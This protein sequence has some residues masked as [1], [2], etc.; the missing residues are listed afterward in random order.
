MYSTSIGT[1]N[2]RSHRSDGYRLP[3]GVKVISDRLREVGVFTGNIVNLT[4][5]TDEEFLRGTGKTDW[6]FEYEGS[7]FDTDQ[8]EDLS[9]HQPFF[10]QINFSETH[11]GRSWDTAHLRIERQADPSKVKIPPYYPDHEWVRRVWA[12][13]L[14]AVMALDRKVGHVVDLLKRDQLLERTILVFMGDNGRAMVRGKQWPYESGLH[15]PLIIRWPQAFP[16]PAGFEPGSRERRLLVSIDVTATTLA[17]LGVEIPVLMQGRVFLGEKAD[18]PRQYVFGGRDR[19]DET[20]DRIR[21]VRDSRFRYLKNFYPERPLLQLNR[22]KEWTYPII[23]LMRK[24]NLRS[25]LTS[26]QARLL[27]PNRPSEEL[28]DLERDPYEVENLA[29]RPEYRRV[30]ERLGAVLEAWMI[31]TNDQG[32][33]PE[34]AE[35]HAYWEER[36]RESYQSRPKKRFD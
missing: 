20:V 10:A 34:P 18:P 25:E 4:G 27:A 12:Q 2:H 6:N 28:Y 17:I 22:Y 3:E 24:L 8:W 29:S 16:R 21:T 35:V 26:I 14:N 33:F 9:S 31:E 5:D 13:Y 1:H 11:R 36:L 7:P 30:K 23:D 32:R 15:V 19:G